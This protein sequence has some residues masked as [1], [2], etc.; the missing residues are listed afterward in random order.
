MSIE[1]QV[2]ARVKPNPGEEAHIRDLVAKL[3]ARVMATDAA[4]GHDIQLF[5]VGSIAKNT[6]LKDPDADVF[7]LFDPKVPRETLEKVGLAIGKEAIDGREHYAEHPYIKGRFMGLRADIVP[8][9]R[10]I[11][12]SQKMT[13]V[14]RTPFHTKYVKANLKTGLQ[15]D[16][17]LLKAF[18]KG[19]GVYG[20][21]AKTMGFSGYLCEL[22]IIRFGGFHELLK[23]A[24]HWRAGMRLELGDRTGRTFDSPMTFIDPVDPNRNVASAISHDRF[25][26]FIAAA[27]DYIESPTME[28][29]FPRPVPILKVGGMK[30]ALAERGGI[31]THAMPRPDLIDDILYSQ[32]RKFERNLAQHLESGGFSV[33]DTSS[34]AMEESLVIIMEMQSAELPIAMLHRGPP[35]SV[36]ENSQSFLAKWRASPDALSAPFIKDGCWHVFARRRQTSAIEHLRAGL[37]DIDAGKDLNRLRENI[38]I[39]DSVPNE[40]EILE[41][42]SMHLDRRAP[43]ER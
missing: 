28:F 11:D 23:N 12:S 29:Y 20:A 5:L 25:A 33:M 14:D 1:E 26:L 31:I 3:E 32:L 43:W 42:L 19:I 40:K 7:L 8:A 13:A 35:V 2:L 37:L 16:V 27:R 18:M 30:K 38:A 6:H 34:H 36:A 22:L 10:I 4:K 41:A 17:R 24:S 15:D 21:D 9:Y 39:Y